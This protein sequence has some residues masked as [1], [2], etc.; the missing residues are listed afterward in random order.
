VVDSSWCIFLKIVGRIMPGKYID[1]E[2]S[3]W[4]IG[5]KENYVVA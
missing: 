5:V 1:R 3:S 4:G 2:D